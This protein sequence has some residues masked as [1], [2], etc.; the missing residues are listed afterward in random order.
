MRSA[1]VTGSMGFLGRHFVAELR[2]RGV[3]VVSYDLDRGEDCLHLFRTTGSQ[4]SYDLVIHAAAR[5]PHRV[6][7]DTDPG[8]HIYNRLLDAAMFDWAIRTRQRHVLYISSCAAMDTEPDDYGQVKLAGEAMAAKARQCG[9]NVTVVRPFSGYGEDQSEL[10][11]FGAFAARARRRDDPFTVWGDGHQVRDWIH[12]EDIV[13]ASLAAV[14]DGT[15]EPVQLCWG[16]GTSMLTLAHMMTAT[17]QPKILCQT[18][19]PS[20]AAYRVGDPTQMLRFYRP[21]VPIGEGVAR[22]LQWE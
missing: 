19:K 4:H 5:S 11:P 2:D 7:I 15:T 6:G 20:G 17:Y 21:T 16:A 1:V 12:V 3:A 14:Y 13:G 18:D 22:A 9:V 8:S 10:F